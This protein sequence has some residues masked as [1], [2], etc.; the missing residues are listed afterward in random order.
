M[1]LVS[2]DL[3]S[4]EP[5]CCVCGSFEFSEAQEVAAFLYVLGWCWGEWFCSFLG[6]EGDW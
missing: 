6:G 2:L 5:V 3:L 4:A 1:E